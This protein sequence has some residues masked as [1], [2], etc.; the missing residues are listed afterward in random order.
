MDDESLSPL[1]FAGLRYGC[2]AVVL[3]I[4]VLAT[5]ARRHVAALGRRDVVGLA[6]LGVGFYAVTQGAQFVAIDNQPAATTSLVLSLTPLAVVWVGARTIAERASGRQLGGSALVAAGAWI[7]FAGELAAT[8]IGMVAALV[9]LAANTISSVAGRSVNRRA[10]QPPVVVTAVSMT[11]GAALLMIV[12][13]G[14]DGL[15]VLTL[16]AGL[17]VAWLAVVNTALAFTLWNLSLRH[18]SAV[19]SS[20]INNLMLIQIAVLAWIFLGEAPGLWGFV[21]IGVVSTGVFL[22]QRARR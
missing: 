18:L 21:G 22:T 9:G 10:A 11:I 19:E 1:T 4:W 2:A 6:L 14:L 7:Y 20:G 8:T 17:I 15:P 5:P 13:T 16:R 12:G 3:W